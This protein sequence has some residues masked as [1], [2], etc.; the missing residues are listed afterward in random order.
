MTG[1]PTRAG[2]LDLRSPSRHL[3]PGVILS[4]S[5]LAPVTLVLALVGGLLALAAPS[6]A[7]VDRDCSDFSTQQAAQTFFERNNPAQDPHRLD[8]S[9][10]DGRACESLPCPCGSTGSNQK[11]D[12]GTKKKRV[13]RQVARVTKVIDGDTIK[14]RLRSGRLRTV[15]FIGI[16]T[17]EVYGGVECGGRKAS[18]SL[19]RLLPV[20]TKVR[21]RSDPTQ[22]LRDRYGRDLR[23]V[24]KARSGNDMNRLQVRRG[25]AR[26]YVYGGKP[27]QLTHRYRMTQKAARNARRGIWRSC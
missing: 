25:W 19:K 3:N 2:V 15:R 24:V 27:F 20:R 23:Y 22:A 8:G 4:R 11:G 21:L 1:S 10:N 13:I 5:F 18:A 17:P 26:V 14:V 12:K 7:F 6:Y 16:D 9:D